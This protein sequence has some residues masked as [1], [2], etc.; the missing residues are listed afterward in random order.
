MILFTQKVLNKSLLFKPSFV[1]IYI[2]ISTRLRGIIL[3]FNLKH[4]RFYA[5]YRTVVHVYA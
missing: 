4:I 3:Q 2:C 5:R 1:I